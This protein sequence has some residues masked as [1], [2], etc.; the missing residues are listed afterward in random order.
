MAWTSSRNP[1]RWLVQSLPL[2]R[3]R[4]SARKSNMS[5][6]SL[7]VE[8]VAD[9]ANRVQQR[10]VEAA[11]DLRAQAAHVHV[12]HVRL[13]IEVIVPYTLEQHRASDH[14]AGV[15]QQELEQLELAR[16]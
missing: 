16:L 15:T 10:P 11:V 3:P 9:A 5:P 4:R 6:F 1:S 7:R 12:D 13:R 2:R 8:A 14:L